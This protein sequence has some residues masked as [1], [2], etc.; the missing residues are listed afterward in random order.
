MFR[1]KQPRREMAKL[2]IKEYGAL[3]P[4]I[5][6]PGSDMADLVDFLLDI[7]ELDSID[8]VDGPKFLFSTCLPE[9][10]GKLYDSFEKYIW[11]NREVQIYVPNDCT[12]KICYWLGILEEPD[13]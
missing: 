4:H 9:E 12:D 2:I 5:F 3:N 7:L 6:D 11:D 10:H 13:V 1:K 8:I